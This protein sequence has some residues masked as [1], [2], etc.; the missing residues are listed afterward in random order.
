MV[1]DKELA[2]A[3]RPISLTRY[4]IEG[5]RGSNSNDLFTFTFANKMWMLK[6][7]KLKSGDFNGLGGD[8]LLVAY[9]LNRVFALLKKHFGEKIV[10]TY[11]YVG[12]S[13]GGDITVVSLQPYVPGNDLTSLIMRGGG[14]MAVF[15]TQ[16]MEEFRQIWEQTLFD[17]EWITIPDMARRYFADCDDIHSGNIVRKRNGEH[18]LIDF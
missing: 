14:E 3:H 16:V 18:V 17:P 4:Q 10:D 1:Y 15:C 12:K 5:G 8:P 9:S 2:L 11:Y 6:E 7:M 13:R